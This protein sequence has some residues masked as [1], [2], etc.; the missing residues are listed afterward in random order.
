MKPKLQVLCGMIASGKSTYARNAARNGAICINDDAIVKLLHSDDYT[1][2]NENLKI[3][4]KTIE[5]QIVGTALA[6]GR[7]VLVDRGLSV[8]IQ[9]RQRWLA[10]ARSFDVS[11]EA[12]VFKNDGAGVHARRRADADARGHDYNYWLKVATFHDKQY[13]EPLLEE[14]FGAVHYITF[15]DIKEGKYI[16]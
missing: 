3:L 7:L 5:N 13:S 4:Y 2:Y 6:M 11:C 16:A 14:G 15:D 1:L 12:V 8:S 9:G 10:L